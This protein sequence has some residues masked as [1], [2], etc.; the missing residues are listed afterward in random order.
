MHRASA[1]IEADEDGLHRSRGL[2]RWA[3]GGGAER[4][5]PEQAIRGLDSG[6]GSDV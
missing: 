4:F 5:G 2:Q 3:G 1:E 6:E